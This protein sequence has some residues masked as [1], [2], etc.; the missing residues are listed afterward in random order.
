MNHVHVEKMILKVL[1]QVL[2]TVYLLLQSIPL[3]LGVNV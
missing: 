1:N 2:S 3:P